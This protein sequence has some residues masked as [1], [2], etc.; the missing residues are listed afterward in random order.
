[1]RIKNIDLSPGNYYG[2]QKEFS[3]PPNTR[4][5]QPLPFHPSSRSQEGKGKNLGKKNRDSTTNGH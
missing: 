5:I 3:M 1:M 2:H 4:G